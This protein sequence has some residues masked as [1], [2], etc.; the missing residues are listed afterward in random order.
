MLGIRCALKREVDHEE[1][2]VHPQ[3]GGGGAGGAVQPAFEVRVP[4][5]QARAAG[6][7]LGGEGNP[8]GKAP[9]FPAGSSFGLVRRGQP[10][11]PVRGLSHEGAYFQPDL[12]H[13]GPHRCG[14]LS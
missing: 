7:G 12:R 6:G 13:G 10:H 2:Q 3:E 4:G 9:Q 1:G 8:S 11:L 14:N 5:D